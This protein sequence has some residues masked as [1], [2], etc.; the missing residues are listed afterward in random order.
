MTG[1]EYNFFE[2]NEIIRAYEV[3]KSYQTT[4]CEPAEGEPGLLFHEFI[5]LL[6][7]IACNCVNTSDSIGGKL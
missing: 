5:F 3:D 6:G 1:D 4:L 2:S 7:R